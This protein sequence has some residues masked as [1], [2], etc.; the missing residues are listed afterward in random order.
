LS[1]HVALLQVD[2]SLASA[3]VG[4]KKNLKYVKDTQFARVAFPEDTIDQLAGGSLIRKVGI[5]DDHFNLSGKMKTLDHLLTKFSKDDSRVLIFSFSTQTMDLIEN[6]L[7]A[8]GHKYLRMDG[9]TSAAKRTELADRFKKDETHF[10]F[11]LS[12]KAMGLG[13]NLTVSSPI[14]T[15]SLEPFSLD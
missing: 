13:L 11:L 15:L 1:S 5:M 7:K 12:T 8:K 10:V 9:Q 14:R 3:P 6:Y 4:S 2:G